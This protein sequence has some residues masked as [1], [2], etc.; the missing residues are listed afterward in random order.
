M[1]VKPPSMYS[2][3]VFIGDKWKWKVNEN[4]IPKSACWDH[5]YSPIQCCCWYYSS[6]QIQRQIH[7]F[8]NSAQ[9]QSSTVNRISQSQS[10]Q[11]KQQQQHS[12]KHTDR[13]S[14]AKGYIKFNIPIPQTR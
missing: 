3:H 12:P 14:S 6:D 2:M 1:Y 10:N 4:L 11:Q 13:T 5:S 9:L 8:A 7:L